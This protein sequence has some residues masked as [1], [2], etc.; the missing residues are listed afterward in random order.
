MELDDN[1]GQ[2]VQALKDLGIADNTVVVWTTDNGAWLDAWPDA[3]Y[4]PFRGMKGSR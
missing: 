3:G 4:T 1:S 2:I